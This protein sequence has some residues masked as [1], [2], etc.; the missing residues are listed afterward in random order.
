MKCLNCGKR[1]DYEK[2]YGICPKCGSFN[3]KSAQ[4]SKE[5]DTGQKQ[6]KT[7]GSFRFFAV[8]FAIFLAVNIGGSMFTALMA[9]GQE[10]KLK[11]DIMETEA[12][13]C[14]HAMG[15]SFS[16]QGMTLSV[17]DACVL[18]EEKAKKLVAVKL[19]GKS[20][21]KWSEE[22]QLSEAYIRCNDFCYWQIANDEFEKEYG[23]KY[24]IRLFGRYELCESLEAEGWITFWLDEEEEKFTLC[25]E[26]REDVNLA[27]IRAIHQIEIQLKE[28]MVN[29]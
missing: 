19:S 24:P 27:V 4:E 1:F 7:K 6:G 3:V 22:N 28:G 13:I 23:D 16:I 10:H 8:S 15:E 9:E 18:T 25:L 14:K 2:Y 5:E 21:G 17:T 20:N 26:E 12:E 11:E 29:G